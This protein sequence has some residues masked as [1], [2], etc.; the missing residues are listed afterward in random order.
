MTNGRA[1][2]D[3]LHVYV[4]GD[5][6]YTTGIEHVGGTIGATTTAF[7]ARTTN[8]YRREAGEWK[9]VHHHSDADQE[10]VMTVQAL[11]GQHR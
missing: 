11:M 5:L 1:E 6:A 3:D 2:V 7:D 10:T 9:I 4:F 8:I